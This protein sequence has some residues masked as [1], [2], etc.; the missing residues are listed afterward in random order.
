MADRNGQAEFEPVDSRLP[1]RIEG[2]VLDQFITLFG[3][4]DVAH[5]YL[6][7][8]VNDDEMKLVVQLGD[9]ALTVE[10]ISEINGLT[11]AQG[12]DLLQRAYGRCILNKIVEHGTTRYSPADFYLRLNHFVKF[13]NWEDIPV[14]DR[15]VINRRFLNEFIARHKPT[16]ERKMQ[17]LEA[18]N[19]L[20]NDTIMLLSEVI[21]MIDAASE[22]IVQPCDCRKL[23]ENCDYPV[24]TCIWLD[25][26]ARE[27][28][29]RGFG[30]RLTKEEAKE[31][32][33]W[34]DKKGLMHT[35]DSE[36]KSRGLH[37][38][39][40]CCSCD[41]YPFR[42]A[43]ELDSKGFWPKSHY[44]AT[45]NPDLCNLC[46][47]CVKRCHFE[48]FYHDGSMLELD[49]KNKKSVGFDDE[50]CWGCGLCANTCPEN[51]IVMTELVDFQRL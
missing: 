31:L 51:A 39:C 15:Q 18:E 25:D 34:S 2:T 42:A 33:R 40:N 16:I 50:K 4:W 17:G 36:W 44:V 7:M 24:E 21:E 13:E 14:E 1:V 23:G 11:E 49:G 37:A 29:D 47:A 26:G 27:S 5:P 41:C 3:V 19:A 6:H 9:R 20:P 30:R 38:I 10:Q 46:G 8:M 32:L 48:A 12:K 45:Y 43:Q 22:I 35:A 28:L